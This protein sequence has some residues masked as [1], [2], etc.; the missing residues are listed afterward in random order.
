MINL[1]SNWKW[2]GEDSYSV[3]VFE[4]RSILCVGRKEDEAENEN[5]WRNVWVGKMSLFFICRYRLNTEVHIK[6][7]MRPKS[8]QR[9]KHNKKCTCVCATG[10]WLN[11]RDQII[12]F[13]MSRKV[14]AKIKLKLTK[15]TYSFDEFPKKK[16]RWQNPKLIVSCSQ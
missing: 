6:Q 2:N 5:K 12:H 7:S 3:V 11:S 15:E 13:A 16:F 10:T 9:M 4:N 8:L 14:S 1:T